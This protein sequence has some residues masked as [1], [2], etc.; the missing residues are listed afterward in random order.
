MLRR[1]FLVWFSA[2]GEEEAEARSF[3]ADVR[4]ERMFA[5]LFF[6]Y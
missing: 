2:E 4:V 5:I 1:P 6:W 3:T